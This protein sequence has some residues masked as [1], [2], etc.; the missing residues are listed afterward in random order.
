M[1]LKLLIGSGRKIMIFLFPFL[2]VGLFMNYRYPDFF[3]I[4]GNASTIFWIS[5]ACLVI[6]IVNWIW[7]A[8]LILEKVPKKELITTGPFAIV[9]HP[10]YYGIAILVLP[11]VGI[12]L[13]SWLG[14]VLGCILYAVAR[15]LSMDE[16]KILSETYGNEWENYCK[17]VLFPW[18]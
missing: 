6:G 7:A 14:I 13:N 9:K 11:W 3:F 8:V 18:L 17:T 1:K 16:E 12:L 5:V 4:N 10:L 2:I 15:L